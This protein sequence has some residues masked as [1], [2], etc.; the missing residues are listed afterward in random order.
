MLNTYSVPCDMY[1][2]C[3]WD[4]SMI[5]CFYHK[6]ETVNFLPWG[7]KQQASAKGLLQIMWHPRRQQCGAIAVLTVFCILEA[8][9]FFNLNFAIYHLWNPLVEFNQNGI[10][11]NT[12]FE[13]RTEV[14]FSDSDFLHCLKLT[15]QFMHI[16]SPFF[17]SVNTVWK[18]WKMELQNCKEDS[19]YTYN[20]TK[21]RWR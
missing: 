17:L 11:S 9:R 5:W 16:L 20:N 12:G 1:T 6:A 7:P 3:V 14:I 4:I 2:S 18:A 10:C 8:R 13:T 15:V 21:C 19:R